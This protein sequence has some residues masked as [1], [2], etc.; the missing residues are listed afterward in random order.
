MSY[1]VFLLRDLLLLLILSLLLIHCEK[2]VEPPIN[3]EALMPQWG[4]FRHDARHTGNVNTRVDNITGAGNDSVSVKWRV[5]IDG[6]L[7][8]TP[9]IG[10]DGTIYFG[11]DH[12]SA[13]DSSSFYALNSDGTIKWRYILLPR[14]WSSPAIGDDGSLFVGTMKGLYAF[15]DSGQLKLMLQN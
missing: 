15:T 14:I 4:M 12:I 3:E 1:K 9:A 8:S 5:P 13:S 7:I 2:S 6:G 11:T 10:S